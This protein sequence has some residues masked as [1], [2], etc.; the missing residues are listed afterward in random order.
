MNDRSG[1]KF[2]VWDFNN[3]DNTQCG[4]IYILSNGNN[5]AATM[6]SIALSTSSPHDVISNFDSF[7]CRYMLL[8]K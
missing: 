7:G 2:C 6:V 4:K 3:E 8:V 1:S 5:G